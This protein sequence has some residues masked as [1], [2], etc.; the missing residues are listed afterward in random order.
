MNFNSLDSLKNSGWQVIDHNYGIQI[1][2]DLFHDEMNK[3]SDLLISTPVKLEKHII[4]SGGN[5]SPYVKELEEKF[6]NVGWKKDNIHIT[7]KTSFENLEITSEVETVSHEI[8]HVIANK[9]DKC[10]A[11]EIEWNTHKVFMNR[12]T[13]FWQEGWNFGAIDLAILITKSEYLQNNL[14]ENIFKFFKENLND[15]EELEG[16]KFSE[17][18]EKEKNIKL[19]F[20]ST[21]QYKAIK[22][23]FSEGKDLIE[24]VSKNFYSHKYSGTAGIKELKKVLDKGYLGRTPFIVLGIPDIVK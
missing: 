7:R 12:D 1:A 18:M 16:R 6:Y 22:K 24:E 8:D 21:N 20:P 17:R 3:L 11:M 15:I 10:I 5:K 13:Q 23:N 14:Q 2:N 4:Q 9:E 19:N